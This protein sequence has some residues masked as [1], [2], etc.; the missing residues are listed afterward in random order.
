MSRKLFG[1]LLGLLLFAG[2]SEA[3]SAQVYPRTMDREVRAW[4][5][6]LPECKALPNAPVLKI[7]SE[8]GLGLAQ[9]TPEMDEEIL[10]LQGRI[11]DHIRSYQA[12]YCLLVVGAADPHLWWG[13]PREPEW[14]HDSNDGL[15]SLSRAYVVGGRLHRAPYVMEPGRVRVDILPAELP[16]STVIVLGVLDTT[17]VNTQV[18]IEELRQMIRDQ[19]ARLSD[20]FNQVNNQLRDL[21][22]RVD[23]H[24]RRITALEQREEFEAEFF[25][26]LGYDFNPGNLNGES[27]LDEDYS[28]IRLGGGLQFGN[29]AAS[30]WAG[31]SP[32]KGSMTFT[33]GG[34]TLTSDMQTRGWGARAALY[35]FEEPF[36]CGVSAGWGQYDLRI[37]EMDEF[38]TRKRVA[39]L[40]PECRLRVLESL[41]VVL[42]PAWEFYTIKMAEGIDMQGRATNG[43]GPKI[44][45]GLSVPFSLTSN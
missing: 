32:S 29:F 18:P 17:Q 16:R 28:L 36:E 41:N 4:P 23:D 34:E 27:D 42:A 39:E 44:F 11:N 1:A 26:E 24:E 2:G 31:I 33:S 7:E 40:G 43:N 25:I 5:E 8:F 15:V 12:I 45:L 9:I 3:L 13:V 10:G 19:D 6:F 35:F 30:A 22:G 37:E 20:I 21:A 38:A 14:V